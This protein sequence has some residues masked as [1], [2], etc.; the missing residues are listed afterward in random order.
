M[1]NVNIN[2]SIR[3]HM[4]HMHNMNI[5][6]NNEYE[7]TDWW[8]L[9]GRDRDLTNALSLDI[10]ISLMFQFRDHSIDRVARVTTVTV[11]RTAESF[12]APRVN[13]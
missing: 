10:H 5:H 11:Q 4:K 9:M 12:S 1:H 8:I 2:L 13:L 3:I 6:L 7:L